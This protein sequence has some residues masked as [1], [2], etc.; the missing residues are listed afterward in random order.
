MDAVV[1]IITRATGKWD[2][3]YRRQVGADIINELLDEPREALTPP[4]QSI[5]PLFPLVRAA[6]ELIDALL[7]LDQIQV[8][9][10]RKPNTRKVR[11]EH[12][13]SI[14]RTAYWNQVYIVHERL[15]RFYRMTVRQFGKL[16]QIGDVEKSV[17][18]SGRAKKDRSPTL[19][20]RILLARNE[21][22]H[23]STL[24]D[25]HVHRIEI[26]ELWAKQD[27]FKS[28]APDF[29]RQ[30]R[31]AR[32]KARASLDQQLKATGTVVHEAVAVALAVLVP[33]LEDAIQTTAIPER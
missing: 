20:D 14:I 15:K 32:R 19:F 30:L 13:F 21:H 8:L 4:P 12:Y 22:V 26:L 11:H 2:D 18:S 6:L 5:D 17:L 1:T 31:T 10:Q 29:G 28:I 27:L 33:P 3:A 23:S 7:T 24:K 25:T 16:P 9:A